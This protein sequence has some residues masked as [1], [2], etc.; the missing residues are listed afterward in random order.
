MVRFFPLINFR[1]QSYRCIFSGPIS[2]LTHIY[3]LSNG[4]G[5]QDADWMYSAYHYS[6]PILTE[7]LKALGWKS[8]QKVSDSKKPA[9]NGHV[10]GVASTGTNDLR[11]KV[12]L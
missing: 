11:E 10:G 12:E 8:E 7:R 2:F 9:A 4:C 1:Y 3:M 5:I 6:H